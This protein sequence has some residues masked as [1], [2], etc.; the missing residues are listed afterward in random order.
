MQCHAVSSLLFFHSV[1]WLYSTMYFRDNRYGYVN[2]VKIT[3]H[4]FFRIYKKEQGRSPLVKSNWNIHQHPKLIH[5]EIYNEFHKQL[6]SNSQGIDKFVW[7]F[8]VQMKRNDYVR[9]TRAGSFSN[10]NI[11]YTK[12]LLGQIQDTKIKISKSD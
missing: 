3:K 8:R 4:F 2:K 6:W 12:M 10:W 1:M 7:C 5:F 11:I 9:L